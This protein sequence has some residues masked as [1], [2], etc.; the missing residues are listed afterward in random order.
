MRWLQAH[1]IAVADGQIPP[2]I[3]VRPEVGPALAR[4]PVILDRA[5]GVG[6]GLQR[7]DLVVERVQ[8]RLLLKARLHLRIWSKNVC[9]FIGLFR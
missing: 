2:T 4:V 5:L 8:D 7:N 6:A 9:M 3:A 1:L